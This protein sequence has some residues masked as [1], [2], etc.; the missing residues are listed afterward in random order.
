MLLHTY[1]YLRYYG[2]RSSRLY[3]NDNYAELTQDAHTYCPVVSSCPVRVYVKQLNNFNYATTSP[4]NLG[5]PYSYIYSNIHILLVI[6]DLLPSSQVVFRIVHTT[7]HVLM[8]PHTV[9]EGRARAFIMAC[10]TRQSAQTRASLSGHLGPVH[11]LTRP[12]AE[13]GKNEL[14]EASPR[15]ASFRI[16]R[17]SLL[18]SHS[19]A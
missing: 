19:R 13:C 3:S 15:S 17:R 14:I 9:H 10:K 7:P 12:L 18:G 8:R 11:M 4:A 6:T 1:A 2:K 5:K 16:V